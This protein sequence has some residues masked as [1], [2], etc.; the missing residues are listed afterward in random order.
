[1]MQERRVTREAYTMLRIPHWKFRLFSQCGIRGM[2]DRGSVLPPGSIPIITRMLR[3]GYLV[4]ARPNADRSPT[5]HGRFP[6]TINTA[7]NHG[8]PSYLLST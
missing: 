5:L 7:A 6:A 4:P 2:V 3:S 8:G 1:M